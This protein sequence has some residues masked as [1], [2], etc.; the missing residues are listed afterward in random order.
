M[1]SVVPASSLDA[2][3][4]INRTQ[5]DRS[6]LGRLQTKAIHPDEMYYYSLRVR[7]SIPML[8]SRTR[9]RTP[10]QTRLLASFNK[11]KVSHG[12][13]TKVRLRDDPS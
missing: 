9:R 3:G 13:S 4:R 2:V 5:Q 7:L 12:C 11:C 6:F 10:D 8:H 1:I